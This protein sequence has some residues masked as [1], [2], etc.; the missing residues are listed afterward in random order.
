MGRR[1]SAEL[2]A[3]LLRA[4]VRFE[5]WRAVRQTRR[6]PGELWQLAEK[7]A[8][9]FGVHRTARALRLNHD[10]LRKRV[11]ASAGGAVTEPKRAP[12]RP[13]A[14]V[15]LTQG[16]VSGG[17]REQGAAELE[18]GNGARL[19]VWWQG[20]AP[21]LGLLSRSFFFGEPS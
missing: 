14:F 20:S 7:L 3:E 15:E 12:A 9:P 18:T 8:G 21:D 19:R 1:R 13:P 11:R 10:S 4:Q 17:P 16:P 6:I 2:P 5:G